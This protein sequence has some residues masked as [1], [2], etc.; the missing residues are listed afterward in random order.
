MG[1]RAALPWF[2]TRSHQADLCAELLADNDPNS[3]E[4]DK[5][6][7]GPD[8]KSVAVVEPIAV[9]I[10]NAVHFTVAVVVA[11]SVAKSAGHS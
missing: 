1:I 11:D 3:D 8:A 4:I 2:A 5:P 10:A 7:A 9:K 6:V